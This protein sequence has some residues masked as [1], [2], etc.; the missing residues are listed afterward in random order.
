MADKFFAVF[1]VRLR[2]CTL[3]RRQSLTEDPK[4]ILIVVYFGDARYEGAIEALD[5]ASVTE[6]L[7]PLLLS[8]VL[9]TLQRAPMLGLD[10]IDN[11]ETC[12]DSAI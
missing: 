8:D 2:D 5:H 11:E 6:D 1:R 7:L 12:R 9:D 3:H 4:R 10:V